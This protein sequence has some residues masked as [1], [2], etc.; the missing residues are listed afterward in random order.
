MNQYVLLGLLVV[1]MIVMLVLPSVTQRKRIKEFNEMIDSLRAG[2]EIRTVGGIIGRIVRIKNHDNER[3]II[4]ETGD[5]GSKTVMEFDITAVGML[6]KS[7]G[8]KVEEKAEEAEKEAVLTTEKADE[9]LEELANADSKPTSG[10][11][12]KK[13]KK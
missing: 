12:A 1:M 9:N 8:K 4:L 11:P 2:D 5:K 10:K 13:S 6:L 3:T 7:S